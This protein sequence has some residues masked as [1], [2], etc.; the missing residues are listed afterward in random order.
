MK[1]L[2]V[3]GDSFM[4]ATTNTW[5]NQF[6]PDLDGSEGKHFTEIL[7]RRFGY[8]YFTLARGACSNTAIS[9]QVD[10]MINRNVDFVLLNTTSPNR[11]EVPLKEFHS[12]LGVYNI[13]YCSYPDQS[14]Q[15]NR[16]LFC[17]D[18]V[19]SETVSNLTYDGPT[20][21]PLPFSDAKREAL[22][23]YLAE[24]YDEQV[25]YYQDSA[26]IGYS[27]RKLEDARI[28]YIIFSTIPVGR[29]GSRV[30]SKNGELDHLVPMSD[31]YGKDLTT[32]RWHTSDE[33]QQKL[34]DLVYQHIVSN[35]LLTWS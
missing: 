24:L 30:P 20:P 14:G 32:R 6:R 8:E 34:A 12:H 15:K 21:Y 18:N 5:G 4:A 22:K 2:G 26:I 3:C 9:L 23:Y 7:A 16:D 19:L 10:E 31:L 11:I 35:N 13:D 25:R 17:H 28:P 27:L 29:H 33:S 1:I